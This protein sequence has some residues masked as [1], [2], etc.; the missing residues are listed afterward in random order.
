MKLAFMYGAA[1]FTGLCP[2]PLGSDLFVKDVLQKAAVSMQES[3]LE[4][5]AATAVIIGVD[6]GA[7]FSEAA[8]PILVVVDRPYL[9]TIVDVPTGAILLLGY[10]VDPT[11]SGGP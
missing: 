2:P 4:A 1:D 11:V 8:A 7:S 9:V 10:V 3:G 6:S 5:A